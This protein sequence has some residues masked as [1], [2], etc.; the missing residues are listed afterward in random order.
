MLLVNIT[1]DELH[2][3]TAGALVA[4]GASDSVAKA[5]A[6]AVVSAELDG[7]AS[8][9]LAYAPIYCEHV[10]CGKVDGQAEPVFSTLRPATGRVDAK[11]GFAHPAI[12]AALPPLT[13]MA[14]QHGIAAVT[15]FNSYNCGVLGHHT[16]RLARAGLIGLGFTNAP[17]SIAPVGGRTPVIGT[18]PFSL[19][20]PDL[21]NTGVALLID[22]S[23]SVV[24][25][26]EVTARKR[27]G[28]PLP[29]GWALDANGDPT[30]DPD[31]AL[32]GS[33]VPSGGAKGFNAGLMTE[34]FAAVLAGAHLGIE[35]SPFA[36]TQGGPP[37]TGQCFIAIDPGAFGDNG[38]GGGVSR[39]L[40]AIAAEDDV[41]LPGERRLQNRAR[42]RQTGLQVDAGLL[43][44]V[45]AISGE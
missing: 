42:A 34:L 16:E 11:C 35:A 20:V 5:M 18:N 24:A 23:A 41:R 45:K 8:H 12:D 27:Q 1:P 13:D 26:S 15:L 17:A 22:Q 33:M 2:H 25:K 4:S 37:Q 10:Q 28:E 38:F 19:A 43:D 36:G 32:A 3:H 29:E 40:A 7:I 21:N 14:R 30:T 6:Q 31:A 9:G 44:R 39:L